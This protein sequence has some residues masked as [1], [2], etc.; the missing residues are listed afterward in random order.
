MGAD[1]ATTAIVLAAG[2]STRAGAPK[3]LIEVRGVRWLERQL[4]AL[5]ACGVSRAVVVLGASRD[6]YRSAIAWMDGAL[7]AGAR[8]G[9]VLVR[10]VVN[11]RPELGPF[12]SLQRAIALAPAG[13]FVL[14]VDVPCAEGSVLGALADAVAAGALAAIPVHG[15]RGGHPVLLGEA[16][17]R[18]LAAVDPTSAD[19]RLDIQLRAR[20]DRIARIDVADARVTMNL[21][22]RADFDAFARHSVPSS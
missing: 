19:A 8:V 17:A 20:A 11:E 2:A 21:N 13:A 18:D 1:A 22:T 6:A 16:L 7:A 14:P 15:G 10:A 3:G 4:E 9:A 5:G 12:S